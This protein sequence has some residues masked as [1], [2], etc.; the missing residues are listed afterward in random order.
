MVPIRVPN[1]PSVKTELTKADS[2]KPKLYSPRL[3][4]VLKQPIPTQRRPS[5]IARPASAA[6]AKIPTPKVTQRKRS[7]GQILPATRKKSVPHITTIIPAKEEAIPW[8]QYDL[9]KESGF[10]LHYPSL[11]QELNAAAFRASS[12]RFSETFDSQK[13]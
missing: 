11:I 4:P 6:S 1:K 2:T 3:K 7:E 9:T 10:S 8:K 5:Q 13:V 12:G